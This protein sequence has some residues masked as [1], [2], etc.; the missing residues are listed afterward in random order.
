MYNISQNERNI[1]FYNDTECTVF[2][3]INMVQYMNLYPVPV[4]YCRYTW[5]TEVL[6]NNNI[7]ILVQIAQYNY[8]QHTIATIKGTQNTMNEVLFV[9]CS[10]IQKTV[11]GL[12]M[13]QELTV[14]QC[15][16]RKQTESC[17]FTVKSD[18][19]GVTP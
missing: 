9:T 12:Y 4:K 3:T 17:V 2:V 16:T 19:I 11:A 14:L 7:F 6:I 8:I 1:F 13:F 5:T 15:I 10:A 18:I